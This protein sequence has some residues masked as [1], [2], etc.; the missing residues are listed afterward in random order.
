MVPTDMCHGHGVREKGRARRTGLEPQSGAAKGGEKEPKRKKRPGQAQQPAGAQQ[1][2]AG[3]P[4]TRKREHTQR[5][6]TKPGPGHNERTHA[7]RAK[8]PE[9]ARRPTSNAQKGAKKK[10]KEKGPSQTQQRRTRAGDEAPAHPRHKNE[11]NKAKMPSSGFCRG[12]DR[13]PRAGRDLSAWGR[14]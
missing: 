2:K 6:G 4:R 8:A 3:A 11:K 5:G 14:L 10:R 13:G 12:T 7:T 9:P 1:D